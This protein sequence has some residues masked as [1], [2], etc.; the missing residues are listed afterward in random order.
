MFLSADVIRRFTEHH[1]MISPVGMCK[2]SD[3]WQDWVDHRLEFI[4]GSGFDITVHD[5]FSSY[6]KDDVPFIGK[7]ERRLPEFKSITA[8]L[9]GGDE[10]SVQDVYSLDYEHF[11][12]DTEP[13]LGLSLS[14]GQARGQ[15]SMGQTKTNDL[16]YHLFPT[17]YLLQSAEVFSLPSHI[18]GIVLPRSSFFNAECVVCGTRIAPGFS[19]QLRVGL[20]VCGRLGLDLQM[21]ARFATVMFYRFTDGNTDA[22][23][24][25]WSGNKITTDGTERAY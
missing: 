10:I 4:E 5:V 18:G 23:Q 3:Q 24:G 9:K 14:R 13:S 8:Q 17:Y 21:G 25:I 7:E 2:G 11:G 1:A 12:T 16:I 20:Y 6:V 15:G 22:Y 19:G